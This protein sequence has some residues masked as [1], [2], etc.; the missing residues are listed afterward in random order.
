MLQD[1]ERR[2]SE[3]RI[4]DDSLGDLA[5]TKLTDSNKRALIII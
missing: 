5:V 2:Q 4:K 1:L 3:R